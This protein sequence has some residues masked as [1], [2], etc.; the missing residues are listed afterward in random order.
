MSTEDT[1]RRGGSVRWV[2]T[3][4]RRLSQPDGGSSYVA[5]GPAAMFAPISLEL[6]MAP[7]VARLRFA[8]QPDYLEMPWRWARQVV[9]DDM[10]ELTGDQ[11]S[12]RV[13]AFS[14]FVVEAEWDYQASGGTCGVVA[15]GRAQRLLADVPVYGRW[16]NNGN[17]ELFHATGLPCD[18]NA[19]GRPNRRDR[20][21]ASG[22]ELNGAVTPLFTYDG[23]PA[24]MW[25]SATDAAQYL[26][27]HYNL[28]ET[29]LAN[30][31]FTSEQLADTRP[32]TAA[33]EGQS[34]WEALAAV[35]GAGGYDVWEEYFWADDEVDGEIR[36]Q[37]RGA[38]S[39]YEIR[40]QQTA[41]ARPAVTLKETNSFS[42][43]V[44]ESVASCIAAPVVLGA[45]RLTELSVFLFPIWTPLAVAYAPAT[46]GPM[47]L[48]NDSDT[49]YARKFVVGGA[50]HADYQFIG[51]RWDAN[52]DRYYSA[53]VYGE[54]IGQGL[55]MGLAVDGEAGSWPLMPHRPLPL[56]SRLAHGVDV[57]AYWSPDAGEHTYRLEGFRVLRDRLA[58][59]ITQPNLADI[60]YGDKADKA[61]QNFFAALVADAT[62]VQ[63]HLRCSVAGPA[64]SRFV[65]AR[66][67]AA[68][69]Q[70]ATARAFDR[71]QAGGVRTVKPDQKAPWYG[72]ASGAAGSTDESGDLSKI[73][74]MIQ[75]AAED[76]AIE[77]SL[78]LPWPET[79]ISLGDRIERIAG[80]DY[81]LGVNAGPA[82]RYPRVVR[83]I[84]NLTP[85]TY[86]TQIIVDTDRQAGVV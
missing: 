47:I 18:F 13:G 3:R 34:L 45:R 79:A 16:M 21:E 50:E 72:W 24:A 8:I 11:P 70:F 10:V 37:R 20:A 63:V 30:P 29:W 62:K 22:P 39:A 81:K 46:D 26:L 52:T 5:S 53:A 66:R 23:D 60:R 76:R 61:A 9:T 48:E 1:I 78:E 49:P 35:A 25:W 68:G 75:D 74:A 12:G 41:P 4:R 77:A 58:I 65:G 67:T 43:R 82:L 84:L 54:F 36:Y 27:A 73:G 55:D 51:R 19:G 44:A 6:A 56:I 57:L 33:V 59:Q 69:T 14:G 83:L 28:A 2:V 15:M 42:A 31:A 71:G 38:G 32:I 64:R 7:A 17:G 86:D 80:I 40:H 85:Q